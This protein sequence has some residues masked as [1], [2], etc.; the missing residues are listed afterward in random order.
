MK[1]L[2]IGLQFL[3]EFAETN[4]IYVDKTRLVHQLV[5]TGKYYFLSRPR[6]FGKSLL[7]STLRELFEGNKILFKDLWIE[8]NWDWSQKNPVVHLSF[9]EWDFEDLNL[10]TAIFEALD[11]IAEPRGIV[12]TKKTVKSR[13]HELLQAVYRQAGQVVLLID[14]YDKPIVHYLEDNQL[15]KAIANR[16]IFKNFYSVLKDAG[17][18]LKFVFITGVSKFTKVS[19]FSDLNHLSDISLDKD[20]AALTGYTQQELESYFENHLKVV[21]N[22]L[23][24]NRET[25]LCQM[26]RWYD[27]YTWDGKTLIYNPFGTITFLQKRAF[28][29]YWF[30]TGTPTFLLEQ[31]KKQG[32]FKIEKIKV[33]STFFEKYDLENIEINQLLFQT[34]Y[35]TIQKMNDLTDEYWLD[36]P[37]KEVHD[38]LYQFLMTELT[39]RSQRPN[40]GMTIDDLKYAFETNR[41][42]RVRVIIDSY[43]SELPEAVFR[44]SSEGLYHGLIHIIFKYLGIFIQSEVHSAHGRADA[45]V[46]T[47]TDIFIFEFKWNES[48]TIALQQIQEKSYMNP[49]R[50]SNK[51]LT[52]IGVNFSDQKRIIEDW[53]TELL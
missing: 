10:S 40:S 45:V 5:T 23:N 53:K 15:K 1:N 9:A 47:D 50:A 48:A 4:S 3:S 16:K 12:L 46:Q 34:G 52:G 27:G 32:Q 22:E 42:P 31:M 8:P 7:V 28:R 11:S 19:I 30:A 37:N 20:Y 29:N 43:L 44:H 51:Q 2:P 24:I 25:L 17:K 13:F 33:N 41:L 36:L 49:Y 14:E 6:R 21:E 18:I 39:R 38:S 35:L 26:K